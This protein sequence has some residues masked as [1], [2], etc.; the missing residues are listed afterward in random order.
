MKAILKLLEVYWDISI[1]QN[2]KEFVFFSKL[3]LRI[4]IGYFDVDLSVL[5]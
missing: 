2:S 1:I 5:C 3:D 4:L